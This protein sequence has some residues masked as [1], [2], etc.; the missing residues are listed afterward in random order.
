MVGWLVGWLMT[1]H[2]KIVPCY[3]RVVVTHTHFLIKIR[4]YISR[5][6]HRNVI[7]CNIGCA[8]HDHL[9][10]TNRFIAM[11]SHTR[12]TKI[13]TQLSNSNKNLPNTEHRN[14][15]T[16]LRMIQLLQPINIYHG[17]AAEVLYIHEATTW[18][19]LPVL[20]TESHKQ[21]AAT[22]R[23]TPHSLS[24]NHL[25]ASYWWFFVPH[26]CFDLPLTV[27]RHRV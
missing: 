23:T 19:W 26:F 9:F 16:K 18:S 22:P 17:N 25:L 8:L 27:N 4:T 7:S 11:S 2:M 10:T 1:K 13:Y 20:P 21:T 12:N 24:L 3:C 15:R 14:H 5:S 6:V